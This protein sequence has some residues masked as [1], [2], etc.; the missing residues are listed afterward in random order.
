VYGLVYSCLCNYNELVLV[1]MPVCYAPNS[2]LSILTL[3]QAS[4]I[5]NLRYL[6]ARL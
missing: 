1:G 4:F 3:K 5:V 2:F 6:L